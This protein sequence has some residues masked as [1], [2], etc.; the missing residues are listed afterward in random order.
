MSERSHS[1]RRSFRTLRDHTLRGFTSPSSARDLAPETGNDGGANSH[2]STTLNHGAILCRV[3]YAPE[4]SF[5]AHRWV[6]A[7]SSLLACSRS[8][9]QAPKAYQ[10]GDP[11]K[12][13]DHHDVKTR[14]L[15]GME[16]RSFRR[17]W[18]VVNLHRL[19]YGIV[20]R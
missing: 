10:S 20:V 11:E 9:I 14:D 13:K 2:E 7:A 19:S 1:G 4:L 18:V 3:A 5:N 6:L 8:A 12:R 16:K 15:P 17:R